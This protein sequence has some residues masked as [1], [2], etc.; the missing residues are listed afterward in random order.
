MTKSDILTR[1]I[2]SNL[3]GK[4]KFIKNYKRTLCN[5][6]SVVITVTDFFFNIKSKEIVKK[7]YT[8]F[9]LKIEVKVMK[10][11]KDLIDTFK[12]K[13]IYAIQNKFKITKKKRNIY[14]Y[15]YIIMF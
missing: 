9:L 10:I 1:Y 12:F 14:L 5:L 15:F 6:S 13:N 2:K 8:F 11:K 3:R 7:K 4:G